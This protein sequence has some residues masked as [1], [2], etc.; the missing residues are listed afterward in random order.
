M[1]ELTITPMEPREN[2]RAYVYRLL[3]HNIMEVRLT[4]GTAI[5]EQEISTRL[6]ISRTPVRE[7]FIHL[8]QD[9]LVEILP[10]RGTF[11]SKIDL[12][13][14]EENRFMRFHLEKAIIQLACKGLPDTY[15][16]QLTDSLAAQKEAM[17]AGECRR[18]LTLDNEMHGILFASVGKPHI[19]QTMMQANLDY[20]R[21]RA[22]TVLKDNEM[23]MIYA[24]HQSLLKHIREHE[25]GAALADIEAHIDRILIDL[26][27]L[28][29]QYPDY[30]KQTLPNPQ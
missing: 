18:F 25:E 5:S 21:T 22:L 20:L 15:W 13:L 6:G 28:Q 26:K 2:V 17:D 11:V 10:Q 16:A 14:I 24:K 9:G 27:G 8:S 3:Y 12:D 30:F 1:I 29:Q 7:A 19:W 23:Q 4:P